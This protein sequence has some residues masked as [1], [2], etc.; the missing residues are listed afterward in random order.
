MERFNTK[1]EHAMSDSE[2]EAHQVLKLAD[3]LI[4]RLE[5]FRDKELK[6]VLDIVNHCSQC[7]HHYTSEK[8]FWDHRHS[9][10]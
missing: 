9:R 7:G 1:E 5:A 10:K 4:A 6:S 8:N 3:R 2:V